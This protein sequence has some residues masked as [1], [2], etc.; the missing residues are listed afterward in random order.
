M[1]A[2]EISL[3]SLLSVV[4]LI[5]GA[6]K[7]PGIIPG[8]EFQLSAPVAVAIAVCF[9]FKRY[10]IAG[11]VSSAISLIIGTHTIVNVTIAMVFRIVAGS[12]IHILGPKL[13]VIILSGPIASFISRVILGFVIGK[14]MTPLIVAAIPGMI[15]TSI[16]SWP[17]TKV[18]LKIKSVSSWKESGSYERTL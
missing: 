17:V 8:T 6:F 13:I 18:I 10:F 12:L 16:F 11:L 9:G 4:I 14:G 1:K 2:K 5:T 15:Y 7:V 3:V